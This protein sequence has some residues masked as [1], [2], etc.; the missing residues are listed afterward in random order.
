MTRGL[1]PQGG[2]FAYALIVLFP[3]GFGL[4]V[5]ALLRGK[6]EGKKISAFHNEIAAGK[7]LFLIYAPEDKGDDIRK[8]MKIR[9]PESEL[10]AVD[11]H[12]MNPL[13]EVS[14]I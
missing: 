3:A 14:H 1:P 10:V 9:H 12:Y 11:D 6:Y 5:G 2:G 8:M 4:W 13:S 7:Y